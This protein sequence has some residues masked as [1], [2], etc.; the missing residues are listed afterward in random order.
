M[1]VGVVV[2]AATFVVI[3]LLLW[4]GPDVLARHDVAGLAAK[5]RAAQL[6]AALDAARGQ[7]LTLGAGIFAAGA[8]IF[9]GQN[10]F[11]SRQ[12]QVTDWYTQAIGQLGSGKLDVRIGGIYALERVARDSARDHP[13]IMEVL[14]A[15]VREHGR[16]VSRASTAPDYQPAYGTRPDVQAATTVIGRRNTR[17]DRKP[18]DLNGAILAGAVL[19]YTDLSHALL[20]HVE[21]TDAI[22][23][24]ANLA[25]ANLAGADLT[26]AMLITAD[27]TGAGLS[28]ADLSRANLTGANL[29]GAYLGGSIVVTGS[30]ERHVESADFTGA[31]FSGARW[32]SQFLV[33]AGWIREAARVY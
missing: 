19:E 30:T 24:G 3:Y 4:Y 27:L 17:R 25:G 21:F 28:G 5:Q 7:L 26:G 29:T 9:T 31:D 1:V 14:A 11:L 12:G 6:P 33:P 22:L 13:V 8:L 20:S 15:F 18:I 10:Y 32:P 23:T 2:G 16:K